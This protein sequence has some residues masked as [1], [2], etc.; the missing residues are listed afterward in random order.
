MGKKPP[1]LCIVCGMNRSA[2][3]SVTWL[4]V[5]GL[6]IS[7]GRTSFFIDPYVTRL[8]FT[9]FLFNVPTRSNM[10]AI[11]SMLKKLSPKSVDAVLVSE[12]HFDHALDA[13][14]FAAR[15][16]STLIGSNSTANIGRGARLPEDQI[17][18][19]GFGE[20]LTFG[21]FIVEF[22]PSTHLPFLFNRTLYDG[23]ISSALRQPARPSAY[24]MGGH[25]SYLIQHP[26]ATILTHITPFDEFSEMPPTRTAVD[27]VF[28]SITGRANTLDLFRRILDPVSPRAAYPIHWDNFFVRL[29]EVSARPKPAIFARVP[30]FLRK[31]GRL[32]RRYPTQ[33]PELFSPIEIP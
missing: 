32:D 29:D 20:T 28:M 11:E 10:N 33:L 21:D 8:S 9:D 7:D 26:S 23:E 22:R 27:A 17:Q 30:E 12:S 15:T 3:V 1:A 6:Y 24:R 18:V 31:S 4:G 16:G 25:F 13:P 2:Q 14:F 5:A 19:V